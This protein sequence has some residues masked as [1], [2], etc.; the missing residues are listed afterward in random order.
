L[1]PSAARLAM[2][3]LGTVL[4]PHAPLSLHVFE[5]RYR[6]LMD[7]VLATDERELGVVLI[8]RGSEVGGGDQR[9]AL[10][11]VAAV[12]EAVATEDG[13]W[14][15]VAVGRRRVDVV[16]WLDDDPYPQAIVSERPEA[17]WPDGIDAAAHLLAAAERAV[18]RALGL[19]G[20]LRE[21]A[22]PVDVELDERPSVAAWQLVHVAPLATYDR[23]RLLA[24]DDPVERLRLLRDLADDEA[25]VLAQ[26]RQ[27]L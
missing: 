26:R 27:G 2:F 11:T 8:E 9:S 25:T 14:G 17:A 22:A 15:V 16:A 20:E 4:V 7:D 1:S 6:A 3:P 24:V 10:G 13:R 18:R 21:A 12:V 23:Q 19:K 5:P